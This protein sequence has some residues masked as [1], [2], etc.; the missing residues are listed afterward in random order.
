MKNEQK[1]QKT[2]QLLAAALPYIQQYQGKTMVVK[3]GGNAMGDNLV[4]TSFARDIVLMKLVGINPIVV[5]G[6]GPQIAKLLEKIGKKTEFVNGMRVTD[7]ETMDVVEMVLGGLVNKEI[8]NLINSNGGR[9]I[10]LTGKDGELLRAKKLSPNNADSSTKVSEIIDL[11]HVGEVS[12]VNKDLLNF[13][14][15]GDF[16]PIIAPIGVGDDGR[17]YNINADL[18]AG[19]VAEAVQAEKLILMTN[20]Q[21]VLDD[22]G[23]LVST[24]TS[25]LIENLINA[26]VISD[27]M[28]PKINSAL[29]AIDNGVTRAHIIDG[30]VCHALLLEIFTNEG[31]GTLI[32]AE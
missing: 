22:G 26:G 6:G 20:T 19:K 15:D 10:G 30:R 24:A 2:A 12:S 7:D 18:V 28:L 5:H 23:A 17:S 16:L 3:Y 8:V 21:G 25:R 27:G 31:I 14:T 4:E 32:Q 11:G 29:S 9:A 1:T 13:F